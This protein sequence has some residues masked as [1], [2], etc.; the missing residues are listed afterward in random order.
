[1]DTLK[2]DR[3]FI[4]TMA[5]SPES[6]ALVRTLVQLGKSLG[7]E[8]LAEGIEE[9]EQRTQLEHEQCDSG[10]GYLFARPLEPAAV[11]SYLADRNPTCGLASTEM[12]SL[13]S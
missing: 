5:D 2:I 4:S 3:S 11:E 9:S 12:H 6:G 1:V 10:Q 13:R 8:T 7:L